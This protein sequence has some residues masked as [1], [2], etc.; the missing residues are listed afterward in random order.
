MP[1]IGHCPTFVVVADVAVFMPFLP[2]SSNLWTRILLL[3]LC[4]QILPIKSSDFAC[5]E[6]QGMAKQLSSPP[7][8]VCRPWYCIQQYSLTLNLDS[9]WHIHIGLASWSL[10]AVAVATLHLPAQ[11]FLASFLSAVA[12]IRFCPLL[13]EFCHFAVFK[14]LNG[15]NYSMIP[16]R[17]QVRVAPAWPALDQLGR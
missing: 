8:W 15:S 3:C 5:C 7:H 4:F 2:F 11:V 13:L 17:P 1:T 14:F 16:V 12:I 6:L 10:S 9:G